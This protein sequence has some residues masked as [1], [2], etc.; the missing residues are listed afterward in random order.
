MSSVRRGNRVLLLLVVVAVMAL[1]LSGFVSLAPNRLVSGRPLSLWTVTDPPILVALAL[2]GALLLTAALVRQSP[3]LHRAAALLGGVLLLMLVFA[4]GR[5]GTALIATAGPVARVALGAGFWIAAS[6]VAL[7]IL[8]AFQRLRA[9]PVAG[10]AT[11]LALCAGIGGMAAC[12]VFDHL[13]IMIEYRSHEAVFGQELGRHLLLVLGSVGAG[14]AIGAPLGIR[15]TALPRLRGPVFAVLNLLQTIPSVALFG[16]LIAPLSL[17]AATFP[18]LQALGIRGIGTAPALIAL[19]CYA[20]L[21]IVRYTYTG[22]A[23][24]DPDVVE[25]ALGMGFTR[26][27]IRR[28]IEFPL[29]LPMLLAGLRIVLVQSIGLAVVAAL[30]GAGGL[31]TFVFQ[32][33]GQDALDLVLLG[34]VPT[35]FL[36]LSTDFLLKAATSTLE[37]RLAR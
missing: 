26:G 14:L 37:R 31:G 15:L 8:D 18:A 13:S 22:F 34:T 5:A 7:A 27:Q 4:A 36:A 24:V 9:G 20:L 28:R 21:P 32:G 11:A 12:G 10:I 19:T 29:A 35:I 17:L 25:A 30:I 3:S 6:S 33:I 2:L 23:G 16:L 1:A